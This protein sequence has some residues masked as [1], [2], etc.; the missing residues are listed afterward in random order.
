M[1]FPHWQSDLKGLLWGQNDLPLDEKVLDVLLKQREGWRGGERQTDPELY[2][3]ETPG[4]G[5]RVCGWG[6]GPF[7]PVCVC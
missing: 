7:R 6:S 2:P 3:V 4:E 1:S 5:R